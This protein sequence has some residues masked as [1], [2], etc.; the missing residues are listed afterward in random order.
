M[1]KQLYVTLALCVIMFVA[2]AARTFVRDISITG[3]IN[4]VSSQE[5]DNEILSQDLS[6]DYSNYPVQNRTN[7]STQITL[8]NSQ[9]WGKV[10]YYNSSDYSI[11][12]YVDDQKDVEIP[13]HSGD[14]IVW[15]KSALKSSYDV[16]VT[17]SSGELNG[18]FSL[19]KATRE[20]RLNPS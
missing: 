3:K 6:Y 18:I 10:H 20:S 5:D 1:K 9:P 17:A 2:I 14:K 4:A 11:T 15:K 13:P 19:A 12:L 8:S 7:F 16:G